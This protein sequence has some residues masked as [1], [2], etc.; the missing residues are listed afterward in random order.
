MRE[1]IIK[2]THAPFEYGVTDC[3]QF[4][5]ECI[6]AVTGKNPM[7]GFLYDDEKSAYEIIESYGSLD[8][9]ITA[10]LGEGIQGEYEPHDGDVALCKSTNDIEIVGVVCQGRIVVLSPKTGVTDWPL[11]RAWNVW[12]N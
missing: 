10:T 9:A 2:Y 4:A 1:I 8:A 11:E 5:G 7:H 12:V 3:C 6:E